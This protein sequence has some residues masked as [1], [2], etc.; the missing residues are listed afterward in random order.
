MR[1]A[2]L[3]HS[4]REAYPRQ[5]G[6]LAPQR[7][8]TDLPGGRCTGLKQ[9][10]LL[11]NAALDLSPSRGLWRSKARV[12]HIG[13]WL[14]TS[15]RVTAWGQR[16]G[17]HW[18]IAQGRRVDGFKRTHKY[19]THPS[20]ISSAWACAAVWDVLLVLTEK[21]S[22]SDYVTVLLT[23]DLGI[24]AAFLASQGREALFR[25]RVC[26]SGRLWNNIFLCTQYLENMLITYFLHCIS[27][28][29]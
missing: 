14:Y 7:H 25:F 9:P 5:P 23:Q 28:C 22:N 6:P 17:T 1:R 12:T 21:D 24:T 8:T 11:G 3:E 26:W 13:H 10:S 15:R 19:T 18:S 27:L 16:A 4:H 2:V 20:Q 29:K